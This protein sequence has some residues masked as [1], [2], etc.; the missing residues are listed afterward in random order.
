MRWWCRRHE[1]PF[2]RHLPG[3]QHRRARSRLGRRGSRSNRASR[4]RWR[5]STTR[6]CCPK[7]LAR[8]RGSTTSATGVFEVRIG[9]ATATVGHDAGQLLNMVF[10]NTSL[11]DDVVL[12]DIAIPDS[13]GAGVRRAAAW[14]CGAAVAVEA[15]RAGA[16]RVG[17]EAAGIAGRGS[18]G[19][20]RTTGV[21]ADWIS[22]RTTMGWRTS[23]IPGSPN[24][25]AP[26][27]RGWRAGRGSTGHPTR[28]VPSLTGESGSVAGA[29]G[30]GA[31][32]GAGLR[33]A[34]ADDLRL[35]RDA[36]AGA[37]F[38]GDGVLRASQPG[39]GGADCPGIADWR[40]VPADGC[41]RGDFP[42]FWRPVRLFARD[43][44]ATGGQR[45]ADGRR[46]EGRPA[47]AGR[48]DDAGADRRNS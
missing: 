44:P 26:A 12:K 31:G 15:A 28:Y 36:G 6:R 14:D 24:G 37:G 27:R 16:D 34:G 41:G 48:R 8:W 38:S 20:G 45:A 32:P 29:G 39:R 2:H 35:S 33:H 7:S 13:F 4:C 10:G 9:L 18:G 30:A 23:A 22:S 11:H 19:A 42:E 43:V 46:D 25:S 17:A 5:R 47:G 3:P 40:P 1:R 21:A